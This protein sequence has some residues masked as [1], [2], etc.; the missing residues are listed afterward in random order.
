MDEEDLEAE[1]TAEEE[2]ELE[3]AALKIQAI[4]RGRMARRDVGALRDQHAGAA[5]AAVAD[6]DAEVAHDT[7]DADDEV[8][9]Q[10]TGAASI[11]PASVISAAETGGPKS[12]AVPDVEQA[13]LD[14]RD[15]RAA[16][17][18]APVPRL[19]TPG[20]SSIRTPSPTRRRPRA[21]KVHVVTPGRLNT[22]EDRADLEVPEMRLRQGRLVKST[23][24]PGG[25]TASATRGV[26]PAS[27]EGLRDR[28]RA[29][30]I[31][32]DLVAIVNL[33]TAA[34]RM[35]IPESDP[36]VAAGQGVV[37]LNSLANEVSYATRFRQPEMLPRIID[38]VACTLPNSKAREGD[39]LVLDEESSYQYQKAM[40][41]T[42]SASADVEAT[43]AMEEDPQNV[44]RLRSL[45]DR[46][47]SE[48][49]VL[50]AERLEAA[51]RLTDERKALETW[52]QAKREEAQKRRQA[53]M[54]DQQKARVAEQALRDRKAVNKEV[55]EN[56]LVRDRAKRLE[57]SRNEVKITVEEELL[58]FEQREAKKAREN[59]RAFEAWQRDKKM[60][61][62]DVQVRRTMPLPPKVGK[63]VMKTLERGWDDRFT[64]TA[65][66]D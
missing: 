14:P 62:K 33:L 22:G 19:R 29:A 46:M 40:K 59:Q 60:R 61:P 64:V 1:L 13:D 52:E 49:E 55:M 21:E 30:I 41:G 20:G 44:T 10:A 47:R 28:L 8:T 50:V 63:K 4:Q 39:S 27:V 12:V 16:M 25:T 36:F 58:A 18:A 3:A 24:G 54:T 26:R 65:R 5:A 66:E 45:A 48:G 38:A 34:K 35:K 57:A 43:M 6:S 42:R 7:H 11:V 53:Q 31:N 15:P 9:S 37:Y 56:W 32:L 2:A 51:A 17:A 23:V